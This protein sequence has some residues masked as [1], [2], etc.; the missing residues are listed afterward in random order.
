MKED[1][2]WA[3]DCFVGVIPSSF[4]LAA[5]CLGVSPA[6]MPCRSV[7]G[8][9]SACCRHCCCIGHV[10]HSRLASVMYVRSLCVVGNI[11]LVLFRQLAWVDQCCVGGC[12]GLVLFMLCGVFLF[13]YVGVRVGWGFGLCFVGV[14]CGFLCCFACCVWLLCCFVVSCFI[15]YFFVVLWG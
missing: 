2:S 9:C 1:Q 7:V 5:S 10:L 4:C 3:N 14:C 13:L 11:F 15:I 6:H 8:C 12:G